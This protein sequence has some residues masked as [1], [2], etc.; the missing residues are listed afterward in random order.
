MAENDGSPKRDGGQGWITT[1]LG[2]IL[3]LLSL[4]LPMIGVTV[5]LFL[6]FFFLSL[7]FLLMVYGVWNWEKQSSWRRLPRIVSVCLL[8]LA[9]F[10]LLGG[11]IYTRYHREHS[12]PE[13]KAGINPPVGEGGKG[14]DFQLVGTTNAPQGTANPLPTTRAQQG[15][16]EAPTSQRIA[17]KPVAASSLKP[18]VPLRS[19]PASSAPATSTT[20]YAPNGIGISGG[21]VN[22]PTVNIYAP[23]DRTMSAESMQKFEG[24]LSTA[25]FGDVVIAIA[26]NSDDVIDVANQL[27]DVLHAVHW[28]HST[29]SGLFGEPMGSAHG[30]ECYSEDWSRDPGLSFKRAANTAHFPCKYINHRYNQGGVVPGG[31]IQVLIGKK[32]VSSNPLAQP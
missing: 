23:P 10:F 13:T 20:I 22:S 29:L 3:A 19:S 2:F 8:A 28:G 5:N 14:A 11:H 17:S 12:V 30:I 24:G 31:D 27:R 4:G 26:S 9:Y 25:P 1:L 16:R 18:V 7:A 15:Q 32:E 6:G 21:T